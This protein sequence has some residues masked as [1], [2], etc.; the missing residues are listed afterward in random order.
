VDEQ[1]A[2]PAQPEQA[3]SQPTRQAS[4]SEAPDFLRVAPETYEANLNVSEP[5]SIVEG[6]RRLIFGLPIPERLARQERLNRFRA[7]AVLSSDALSSVA[8]A[9]EASLT[10]LVAAGATALSRNLV[11]GLVTALLMLMVGASYRQT[12]H[13]YPS[14]G[15]SYIVARSNLGL[16]PGLIAGSALLVDYLLTV[17]VSVSSGVDAI[18]SA[19]PSLIPIR[20]ELDL[21]AILLIML[22]N[23]RGLRE[24]GSIFALPTYL[25]LVSYGLMIVLGL[26]RAVTD[27][28]LTAPIPPATSAFPVAP[29]SLTLL[30]V[31]TAFASGASAMTGVEAISNGVPIFAGETPKA[32]ARHA[33]QTLTIMIILLATFFLG[34]TYLA[35]RFGV[36]P[37]ASGTP[38]VTAQIAHFA[39]TGIFG[40][41]FYVVQAATLL[42]LVF[43]ANTSFNGFPRLTAIL[44]RDGYLPAFFAYRGERLA[45]S[46]GIITLGV[47]GALIVW[48][49]NG[50][51]VALINLYAVGVFTAFTLSQSG[52]VV[53]WAR[54]RRSERGWLARL[55][56]NALGAAATGLVTLVIAATKFD[57]GAWIIVLLIP[58]LVLAFLG[59]HRYYARPKVLR[60][61]ATPSQTAAI[62]ILPILSHQD[63]PGEQQ[64]RQLAEQR[65]GAD[66]A[67]DAMD[68][69][70]PATDKRHAAAEMARHRAWLEVVRREVAFAASVAP[71]VEL[72]RVVHD[73]AE[74][75]AFRA[76]WQHI[77]GPQ[78]DAQGRTVTAEALISPYRTTV[79]PL[80]SFIRWRASTTYAGQSVVVLLPRE[81]HAAWWQ[82]PLRL[83]VANRLR[84]RLR[85][86]SPVAVQ[87]VP[88][89]LGTP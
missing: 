63:L 33:G 89:T 67:D 23:L 28:G 72:I 37:T 51:V 87:D 15:G 4:A 80:A 29:Q 59:I 34:T 56:V 74:A 32:R 82:W 54:L 75:D 16:I 41:L 88:Y 35:W 47:L 20:L 19:V 6:L 61:P 43:A 48:V 31:L 9:T 52:M 8:Y 69:P 5:H 13:A 25:F 84:A 14:G 27:G 73:A 1:P 21:A 18:A 38:T 45:F 2:E 58:L 62:A 11:I 60:L 30:L 85:R 76:A 68:T 7:L 22:I 3:Q 81:V 44:S 78:P 36:A 70:T 46:T 42:I 24:A 40:W 77:L 10:I 26:V 79:R 86:R 71:H 50:N 49:F 53:H 17:S 83:G 65:Q 39:S 57:R 55:V 12:I 66:P 64:L